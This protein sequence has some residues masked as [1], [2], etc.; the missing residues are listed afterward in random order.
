MASNNEVFY[1]DSFTRGRVTQLN[2]SD[3]TSLGA[4][5]EGENISM[6]NSV[7]MF[8]DKN[9]NMKAVEANTA[10]EAGDAI[11]IQNASNKSGN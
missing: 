10:I 11:D 8:K 5:L 2:V 4:L 7:I 6:S 1:L 3:Y 9:G